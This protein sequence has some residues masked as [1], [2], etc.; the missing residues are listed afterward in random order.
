MTKTQMSLACMMLQCEPSGICDFGRRFSVREAYIPLDSSRKRGRQGR[1]NFDSPSDSPSKG[2]SSVARPD[3]QA[4][5][6]Q[7]CTV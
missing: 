1:Q 2:S 5:C 6:I 3:Q 4:Q 7:R